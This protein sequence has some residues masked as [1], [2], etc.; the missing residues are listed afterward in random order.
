MIPILVSPVTHD[1]LKTI[2]GELVH[3]CWGHFKHPVVQS[4]FSAAVGIASVPTFAWVAKKCRFSSFSRLMYAIFKND[5]RVPIVVPSIR[6]TGYQV[7]S[8]APHLIVLPQNVSFIGV[9]EAMG[10]RELQQKLSTS[11]RKVRFPLVA[12]ST[13]VHLSGTFFCIGGPF[14]NEITAHLLQHRNLAPDLE[15]KPPDP[16]ARDLKDQTS[17]EASRASIVGLSATDQPLLNDFGFIII[18]PNPYNQSA[19]VCV[20]FGL[21]P[22]GSNAAIRFLMSPKRTK[23][24][25]E[26]LK[27][28]KSQRGVFAVVETKVHGF[29]QGL[30]VLIKARSL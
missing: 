13:L 15:L 7:V 24:E 27:L 1:D 29:D 19:K 22:Q 3:W 20:L 10:V 2:L 6:T 18:A 23:P 12:P 5:P 26:F 9:Q 17:Y 28:A 16:I 8:T 11:Y 21:W 25:K 4:V 30:P 14:A